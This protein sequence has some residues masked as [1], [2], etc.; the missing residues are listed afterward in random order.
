MIRYVDVALMTSGSRA[1][2]KIFCRSSAGR[3][4][5]DGRMALVGAIEMEC[6]GARSAIMRF[7]S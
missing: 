6:G 5:M 3:V 7:L 1:W 4:R 2:R